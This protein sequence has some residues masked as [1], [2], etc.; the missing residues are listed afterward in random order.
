MTPEEK[1]KR[2]NNPTCVEDYGLSLNRAELST[3]SEGQK[4]VAT[5]DK[6]N[7]RGG[8][9]FGRSRGAPRPRPEP[10]PRPG[11]STECRYCKSINDPGI[12]GV[13]MAHKFGCPLISIQGI[14]Q[15]KY[16]AQ[17]PGGSFNGPVANTRDEAI[18]ILEVAHTRVGQ[19]GKWADIERAG[20]K[21]Q[22][23]KII[24]ID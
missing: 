17:T 16:V 15:E 8:E 21:I 19:S 14:G 7:K 3:F 24:P 13:G 20:Y 2:M 9:M 22:K 18:E 5:V 1:W 4:L 10:E 6:L 23:V 11:R 12:H